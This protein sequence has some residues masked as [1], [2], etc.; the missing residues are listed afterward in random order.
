[1]GERWEYK[2]VYVSAEQWTST[3]LPDDTNEQF[4]KFGAEGWEL[5]AT[6]AITR[7]GWFWSTVIT[8]AIIGFFKRRLQG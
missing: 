7:P 8:V 3:G 4:D 2:I 1:M 6:E 5:V